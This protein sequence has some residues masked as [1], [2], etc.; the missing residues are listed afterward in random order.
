MNKK[1]ATM[2]VQLYNAPQQ[3]KHGHFIAGKNE[4]HIKTA[5][6]EIK[7][8][9]AKGLVESR[10]VQSTQRKLYFPTE[11]AYQEA[12]RVLSEVDNNGEMGHTK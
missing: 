9:E 10:I 8:L 4:I 11:E 12:V 2:I 7:I 6:D 1:H 3:L 5:K